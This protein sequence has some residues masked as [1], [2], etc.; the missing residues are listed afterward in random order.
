M[1]FILCVSAMF[2]VP[3][4]YSYQYVAYS[5]IEFLNDSS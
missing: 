4:L 5:W 2:V 3:D 1:S